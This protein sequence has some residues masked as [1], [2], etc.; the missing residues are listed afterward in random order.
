MVGIVESEKIQKSR[1]NKKLRHRKCDLT[2]IVWMWARKI[3]S[4]NKIIGTNLIWWA[5]EIIMGKGRG[6]SL[7]SLKGHRKKTQ[8][9]E[10][11]RE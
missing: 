5:R 2:W 8:F 7:N 6:R 4:L 10:S 11:R 3:A 9:N 1:V